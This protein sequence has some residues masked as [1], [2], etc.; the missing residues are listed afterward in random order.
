MDKLFPAQ[1]RDRYTFVDLFCGSCAVPLGLGLKDVVINDLNRHLINFWRKVRAGYII[2]NWVKME[3]DKEVY[4]QNRTRFNELVK[5]GALDGVESYGL[6]YYLG[7]TGFNGLWRVNKKGTHNVPFGSYKSINYQRTFTEQ[8]K[9]ISQ[10]MIYNGDFRAVKLP[11]MAFL[12]ADPPYWIEGHKAYTENG[13]DWEDQLALAKLLGTHDGPVVAHN[14]SH[15]D[16]VELYAS[17]GFSVN[18]TNERR[19]ISSKASTRAGE[20]CIVATKNLEVGDV[21]S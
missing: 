13:F 17:Y 16:I 21:F 15:P 14:S 7:K 19:F 5:M 6:F 2:P 18:F 3:N 11:E 8:S 4:Y 9:L 12:Y 20:L 10:W 1:M